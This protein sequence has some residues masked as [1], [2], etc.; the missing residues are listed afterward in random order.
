LDR[1]ALVRM[2]GGPPG[3]TA[4]CQIL[5]PGVFGHRPYCPYTRRPSADGRWHAPDLARAR[6]LVAASGTRGERITVYGHPGH[7]TDTTVIRYTAQVLRELGYHAQARIRPHG[8]YDKA[9]PATWHRIQIAAISGE[10]TNPIDFFANYFG[11]AAPYGSGHHWYCD[12]RLDREGQHAIT[13][14]AT[15]KAAARL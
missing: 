12:P 7:V 8:Y 9:P 3:A 14:Y 4:T 6:Q 5:P 2:Y 1:A 15:D 10:D 13:L 11:C